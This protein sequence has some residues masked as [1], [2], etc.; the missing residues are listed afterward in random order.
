VDFDDWLEYK[1]CKK[2]KR[3]IP[4]KNGKIKESTKFTLCT[5][6]RN[7][8]HHPENKLNTKYSSTELQTSINEMR[9]IVISLNA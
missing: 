9:K 6:I 1:G 4:I 3:W 5:Y 8:I 2:S 7:A